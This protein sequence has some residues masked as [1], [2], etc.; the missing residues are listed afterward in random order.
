MALAGQYLLE[1]EDRL[2]PGL[3][4][5][6]VG[7]LFLVAASRGLPTPFLA[8]SLETHIQAAPSAR[9]EFNRFLISLPVVL[10]FL[11]LSLYRSAS[12]PDDA[13]AWVFHLAGI[14][15]FL[16]LLSRPSVR[17]IGPWLKGAIPRPSTSLL[18][19]GGLLLFILALALFLRLLLLNQMPFGLWYDEAIHGMAA[20]RILEEGSYRPVFVPGANVASAM[21]FIQAASIWLLGRNTVALRLPSVFMDLGLILLVYLL[22]RRFLGWRVALAI[23]F[24]LAVSSWDITWARNAMPGVT[25]P[26]FAVASLLSFLWALR[27][28]TPASYALAGVVLGSGFWYYQ[29][30]RIMPV[31]I[32]LIAA[33]VLIRSRPPMW[34]FARRFGVY[35]AGALLVAAPI[36]QYAVTHATE[37]WYRADLVTSSKTGSSLDVFDFLWTNLDR[38]LLMFNFRGDVNGRHN[39]PGEPMLD[40]AVAALAA[41]GFLFCLS[42]P[43]RPVPFLLLVWFFFALLPGL[44]T[45][46]FEAP[47]TL[48]AIGSLPVAYIFAGVAIAAVAMAL[49]PLVPTTSRYG[50]AILGIPL[51]AGMGATAYDNLH[52][53]FHLQRNDYDVWAS[54]D[55]VQTVVAYRLLELPS[56]DY[57]VQLAPF[58]SPYPVITFLVPNGPRISTFNPA[59]HPPSSTRGDGALLFL[60][61]DQ[62]PYLS[63]VR[64][65]YP[66]SSFSVMDFGQG[67]RQPL[68]YTM[69]L[70]AQ[71][72][73]ESQGLTAHYTP[74]GPSSQAPDDARVPRVD[75]S[76]GDESAHMPP[77]AVEWSGVLY[78]PKYADYRLMLEGS[79]QVQL[80][81]DDALI[82]DGPGEVVLPLALGNH[83]LL[84]K[85]EVRKADGIIRLSWD[86]P[87]G[88][89]SVI[90]PEN[91]YTGVESRGLLGNYLPP[92]FPETS[93][94]FH[95]I[96]P[97]VSYFFHIRPF[98]GEFSILWEG[99]LEIGE[100]GIYEFSLESSGLSSLSMDGEEVISNPGISA[101][102]HA[103]HEYRS[104]SM[105]L[106]PGLH[107]IE[108]TFQHRYGAPQIYLQWSPPNERYAPLPWNRLHP[109]PPKPLQSTQAAPST[110]T[111]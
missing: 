48:R 32:V 56:R 57:D 27:R 80:Y 89:P 91:L 107:T 39:L 26:F 14:V 97:T 96:D 23:A 65:F 31:V 100:G 94:G 77:F 64:S 81:L 106:S 54:F 3:F 2:A 68:V 40:F 82:Q 58:L 83:A 70:D 63:R 108:I 12:N 87:A 74:L 38:Y 102:G 43:H 62:E 28:R 93:G 75:L 72:I 67:Y 95:Q 7:G 34:E 22:A 88:Q 25:M 52:T 73:R 104:A 30:I 4:L 19:E 36:L 71:D 101:G 24:L 1:Y 18:V 90:G 9:H 99:D 35:V 85:E 8:T 41:L 42:R 13:L 10:A 111:Q 44:V 51:L 109:T 53:Y 33:Y 21:I 45:L 15:A 55:P 76:W 66:Q 61:R 6:L 69:E 103:P 46:P 60:D 11:G 16:L 37:F 110:P 78:V 79:P 105:E 59:K 17:G 29:A 20:V 5:L 49:L 47:N 84:V 98:S 92:G 86:P 50:V